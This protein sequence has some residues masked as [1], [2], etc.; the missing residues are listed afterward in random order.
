MPEWDLRPLPLGEILDRTFT[1]YRRHFLLFVGISAIPHLLIL[2]LNLAQTLLL[3]AATPFVPGAA[4]EFQRV[5]STG[6]MALGLFGGMIA[7]VVYLVAYLFSQGG[8][9]FAVS[10]LY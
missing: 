4:T 7:L 2:G 10:E 6:F 9:I 1:L 5:P 3:R 8:T